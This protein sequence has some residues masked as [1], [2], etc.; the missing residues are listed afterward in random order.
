M[1]LLHIFAREYFGSA[2]YPV[3]KCGCIQPG[4]AEVISGISS[5]ACKL[6]EHVQQP[7]L[8]LRFLFLIPAFT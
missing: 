6:P 5:L 7:I 1:S 3:N 2:P 4:F 8:L